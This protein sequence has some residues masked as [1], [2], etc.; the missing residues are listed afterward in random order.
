MPLIPVP[1]GCMRG[2]WNMRVNSP[3]SSLAAGAPKGEAPVLVGGGGAGKGLFGR[4]APEVAAATGAAGIAWNM[5]VNSPGS[6][7]EAGGSGIGCGVTGDGALGGAA[8]A[9]GAAPKSLA[10]SS[11]ALLWVA[12]GD[13]LARAGGGAG[14]AGGGGGEAGAGGATAGGGAAGDWAWNI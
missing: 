5:R 3:G 2:L 10:N 13:G 8:G 11:S 6:C 7:L 14:G 12:M 4:G 1:A 9:A